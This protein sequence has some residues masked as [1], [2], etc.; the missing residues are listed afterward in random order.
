MLLNN[1]D[2]SMLQMRIKR[3]LHELWNRTLSD[4]V[5]LKTLGLLTSNHVFLPYWK[6]VICQMALFHFFKVISL[7]KIT[8]YV[9]SPLPPDLH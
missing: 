7:S 4:N 1:F 2:F 6:T 5:Y 9:I 8:F 3:S